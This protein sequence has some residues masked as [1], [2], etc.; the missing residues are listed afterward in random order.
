MAYDTATSQVSAAPMLVI[1][2][3]GDGGALL[4]DV[5]RLTGVA[6]A[7]GITLGW[8][9]VATVM[10]NIGSI[11]AHMWSQSDY[12]RH[13]RKPGAQVLA[14]L[15]MVLPLTPWALLNSA[16]SFLTVVDNLNVFLGSLMAIMFADYFLLRCTTVK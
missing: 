7:H 10:A 1:K 13:P 4:A 9:L 14:Q 8:A 16:T 11:A 6:P 5:S 2:R 3:S 15:I 12:T